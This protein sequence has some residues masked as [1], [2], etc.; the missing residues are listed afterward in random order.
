MKV[1]KIDYNQDDSDSGWVFEWFATKAAAKAR[2]KE[3][4]DDLEGHK[5]SNLN[6]PEALD[7]PCKKGD[8][9]KF[10]NTFAANGMTPHGN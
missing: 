2:H 10:L 7:V 4:N 6:E 1:W 8:L 9:V 3:L 5:V